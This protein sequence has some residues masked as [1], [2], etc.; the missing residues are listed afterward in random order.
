MSTTFEG[1]LAWIYD[2]AT[3][4]RTNCE[5]MMSAVRKSAR[6][7][8]DKLRADTDKFPSVWREVLRLNRAMS[9]ELHA[10]AVAKGWR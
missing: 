8:I 1:H 6:G 10:L 3:A 4:S 7:A 9:H 5:A 2:E